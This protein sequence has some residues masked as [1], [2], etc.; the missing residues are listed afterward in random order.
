M[1]KILK[2]KQFYMLNKLRD[3]YTNKNISLILKDYFEYSL[4]PKR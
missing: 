3:K 1:I 4:E 2:K